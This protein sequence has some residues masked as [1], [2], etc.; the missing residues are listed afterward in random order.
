MSNQ[1]D[2]QKK[3]SVTT[4][5]EEAGDD[6]KGALRGLTPTEEKVVRMLEGLGED[7]DRRLEFG[8]GADE[9]SRLKLAL[10]EHQ[11]S[12][13]IIG[14]ATPVDGDDDRQSPAELL[15]AWLDE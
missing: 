9:Q 10:I 6:T 3:S 7:G 1:S 15:S 8:L 13:T 4:T 11:L 12:E 2:E 14:E 5:T